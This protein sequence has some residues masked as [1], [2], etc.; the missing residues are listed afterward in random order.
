MDGLA[1]SREEKAKDDVERGELTM[2]RVSYCSCRLV[3]E[4]GPELW[5]D[6]RRG[7]QAL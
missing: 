5:A 1:R 6:T 2:G 4:E 3:L 7:S